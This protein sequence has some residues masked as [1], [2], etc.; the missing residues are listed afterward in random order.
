MRPVEVVRAHCRLAR[1]RQTAGSRRGGVNAGRHL[2][3]GRAYPPLPADS[4]HKLHFSNFFDSQIS[5]IRLIAA[6]CIALQ[7]TILV[8]PCDDSARQGANHFH[9]DVNGRLVK[10]KPIRSSHFSKTK[11]LQ[12]GN[13]RLLHVERSEVVL[14]SP[15]IVLNDLILR[16]STVVVITQFL[17]TTFKVATQSNLIPL[18]SV[19]LQYVST[20]RAVWDRIWDVHACPI[21]LTAGRQHLML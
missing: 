1:A 3:L 8:F 5:P 12:Y 16:T 19:I 6:K 21:R 17:A 20:M 10:F 13:C 11:A 14:K 4:P 2:N 15:S 7:A 9:Q 18:C